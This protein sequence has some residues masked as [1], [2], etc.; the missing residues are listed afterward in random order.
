[1]KILFSFIL[2]ALNVY[3]DMSIPPKPVEQQFISWRN[4]LKNPGFENGK[5]NWTASAGTFTSSSTSP[6]EGTFKGVWDAS[7]STQTL[8][9]ETWTIIDGYFGQNGVC[10]VLL[11]ASSGSPTHTLEVYDGTNILVS[12]TVTTN[13]TTWTR[14]TVNFIFPSSGSVRCRLQAQANEPEIQ[15]DDVKFGLANGFNISGLSQAQF[16]GSAY[17]ATTAS[18]TFTRTNTALGALSDTDCPGPTVESNPGPGTIQTTDANAPIVTVN[19]LPPGVYQACYIGGNVIATSAQLSAVAIN[20]GTTTVGQV[21]AN[22]LTTATAPFKV[23]G[24]FTYTVGGNK[25]F[26]LYAS[27]AA[28]AFNI[29]LTAS[30]QRLYFYLIKFPSSTDTAYNASALPASWSGYHDSTCSWARTNTSYGDPTTDTTCALTER[31]NRNFGTVTSYLSG[32]DKLP[33]IVF[34]P[35]RAG[36]YFICANTTAAGSSLASN[37]AIKLWDGTTTIAE[38]D[39]QTQVAT[40]ALSIS[41]CGIYDAASVASKTISLQ[42]KA[43]AG[44]ITLAALTAASAVEWSIFATDQ[45]FPA[46]LLANSVVSTY[47]GVSRVEWVV[48]SDSSTEGVNCNQNPCV[49][50]RQS[51]GISSVGY[52]STGIYTINF[53]A[54]TWSE[55]PTCSYI[56]NGGVRLWLQNGSTTSTFTLQTYSNTTPTAADS[57]GDVMCVGKR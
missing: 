24:T 5:T 51:G 37:M 17:F 43:S 13:T 30:N 57:S 49:I 48:F 38:R 3:A 32:S 46:P 8:S 44:S 39:T 53:V 35:T 36:R 40:D 15:L 12:Q 29:D 34:T 52:T 1:M 41:L 4:V 25:S 20:D 42:T 28:N 2:S 45:S 50:I 16:I 21:T 47:A 56:P 11:K 27:S 54:G 18:C 22:N 10:S 19:N 31:T 7:A 14:N 33:G 6:G 9:S 26:E 55:A 23:C